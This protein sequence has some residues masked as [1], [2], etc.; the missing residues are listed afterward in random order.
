VWR[1]GHAGSKAAGGGAPLSPFLMDPHH[2]GKH[3][4]R[5][6]TAASM[7]RAADVCAT[8]IGLPHGS[9]VVRV[10]ASDARRGRKDD[11]SSIAEGSR[12]SGVDHAARQL[13][14]E[15]V[16]V[17]APRLAG[18]EMVV[19][20]VDQHACLV[21]VV[22]RASMRE[23]L[24]DPQKHSVACD[25]WSGPRPLRRIRR[26]WWRHGRWHLRWWKGAGR[27]RRRRRSWRRSWR[28]SRW[29]GDEK[30]GRWWW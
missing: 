10:R 28:R 13:E 4:R 15:L 12:L 16:V 30:I 18:T 17:D 21:Q 26:C 8:A 22:A 3:A 19:K 2:I 11:A 24:C 20:D 1:R 29:E 9:A 27:W 6:R 14:P 5:V 25:S 23:A 7:R